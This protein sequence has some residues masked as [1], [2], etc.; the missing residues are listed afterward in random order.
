[1]MAD[2]E[3]LGPIGQT[4]LI[5]AQWPGY[6]NQPQ[7]KLGSWCLKHEI[8]VIHRHTSGHA[9]PALLRR[10]APKP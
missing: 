1:M 3:R 2:I 7:S 4:T 8:S 6:L 5:Y 9:D 10:Y